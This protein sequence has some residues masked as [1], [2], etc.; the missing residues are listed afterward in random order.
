MIKIIFNEHKSRYGSTRIFHELKARGIPCTRAKIAELMNDM[1]LIAKARKK[2]K[3]TTDSNHNKQVAPNLLEQDFRATEPNEKWVSDIT[4]IPTSEG[5]LYL[6]VFID[7]FSRSVIGWPMSS[8]LKANLVT[9]ALTMALFKR[10]FPSKVIVHSDRGSQYCS[11]KYQKLLN[12]NS[13]ICSMSATGCCYDNAAMESFF[14]TLKVELVHREN[15]RSKNEA[16]SSIAYYIEA[17]YNRKR[18]HS[19]INYNIPLLYE[20]LAVAA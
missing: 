5:W 20:S 8:R 6:C 12:T 18:R 3:V 7:L 1:N 4:Y 10:K 17:Y 14:H 2:Y 19:A 9:D 16:S 13:L 15:Y 11:D